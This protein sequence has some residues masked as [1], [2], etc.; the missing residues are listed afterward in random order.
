MQSNSN[1][2]IN[3]FL[4]PLESKVNILVN[5]VLKSITLPFY[6]APLLR[7]SVNLYPETFSD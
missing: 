4:A 7:S 3:E 5:I 6:G 1:Y 2:N